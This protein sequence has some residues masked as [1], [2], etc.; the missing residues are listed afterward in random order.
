MSA[1]E[2]T[3]VSHACLKIKGEFGGLV[4]DPWILNEPIFDFTTWKYPAA[5]LSPEEVLEG[6]DTLFITH[7]HED[8]FHMPSLDHFPRDFR[9]LL[10]EYTNHPGLRAQTIERTLRA[11][12]FH[13]I[14]KIQPWETI[15][16]GGKTPFTHIPAAKTRAHEWENAGFVIDHP[17]CKLINMNDN[18]ID[19]ELAQEIHDRFGTFDIGFIQYAG[20]SIFPGCFRMTQ[21][22]M[23]AAVKTRR[24]SFVSQGYMVD[25]MDVKIIVPH[26]GDFCWLDDLY[27]D[28]NWA[29]RSTPRLFENLLKEHDPAG[30]SE[31]LIMYPGDTWQPKA[32]I[33]RNHPPIDWDHYV[34]DISQ[35]KEKLQPK[36]DAIR[37]WINSSDLTRLKDRTRQFLATT[38][39]W[40]CQDYVV[41]SACVRIEIEGDHAGFHFYVKASPED[42]FQILWENGEFDCDHTLFI[43]QEVW[44]GILEGKLTW[45]MVQWSSK[46]IQHV[47]YRLDI[48]KMYIW[49]E[50]YIDLMNRPPQVM[51]ESHQFPHIKTEAERVC[52]QKG[53]FPAAP[54]KASAAYKVSKAT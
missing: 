17:G 24:E 6:M 23:R 32:G 40:V 31:C 16:L 43:P 7:G 21:E 2:V 4:C 54:N 19:L 13:N 48:G 18:I 25:P 27:S 3:M 36:V 33:T 30:K 42:G 49:M 20:V 52:P 41:F 34:E 28:Y 14:A 38:Q 5:V 50:Y 22:E 26:A 8:H 46:H 11:M 10:P 35:L 12:G 47:P 45:G 9:I 39:K 15:L 37:Q 1:L 53:V 29:N 51:I 44:A